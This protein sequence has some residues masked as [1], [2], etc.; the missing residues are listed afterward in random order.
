MRESVAGSPRW[1]AAVRRARCQGGPSYNGAVTT[2]PAE[3]V[4]ARGATTGT[5]LGSHV[6]LAEVGLTPL[7]ALLVSAPAFALAGKSILAS[8]ELSRFLPLLGAVL[9][10][11][12]V[13]AADSLRP[14]IAARNAKQS[15]QPLTD[16]QVAAADRAIA[17]APV[18]GALVRWAIWTVAVGRRR[19][20][21]RLARQARLGVGPRRRVHRLPARGR[22]RGR[23]RARV[24]ARARAP[25]AHGAAELRSAAGLRAH[26]PPP[27]RRDGRRAARDRAR[28]ER[29]ARRRLH[30]ADVDPGG[31]AAGAH[32]AGARAAAAVLVRV[33]R[34]PHAAHRALLRRGRAPPRPARP[35]ARRSGGHRGVS[36]GA[37]PA[38]PARR[39]SGARVRV[40]RRRRRARGPAARRL[41]RRRR[42]AACSAPWAS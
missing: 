14:V 37:G 26:L 2:S 39:V 8:G 5:R 20:A 32:G 35:D 4:P 17:R 13:R 40:R 9:F 33:A 6:V 21:A 41:R 11:S 3:A 27:P 30:R 25:A 22:R 12:W 19:R 42:R 28:R 23:A 16:A 24:G 29:R 34:A 31:H 18:E 36:R 10:V 15:G 38:V 7:E 1:P